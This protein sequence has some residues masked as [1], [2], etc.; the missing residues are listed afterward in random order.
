MTDRR[1]ALLE[2]R[3]ASLQL[4]EEEKSAKRAEFKRQEALMLR[5]SRKRMAVKDFVLLKIIGK[6]AFV[7]VRLVKKKDT[8]EI[9]AMKTM[10]KVFST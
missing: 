7:Q 4:S 8:G 3:L 5:Q 10:V 2:E 6:G 9:L 1:R